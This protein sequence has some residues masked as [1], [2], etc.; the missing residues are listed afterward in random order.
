MGLLNTILYADR[1]VSVCVTNRLRAALQF[2]SSDLSR[3]SNSKVL[4]PEQFDD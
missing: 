4:F 2:M 1:E 3:K